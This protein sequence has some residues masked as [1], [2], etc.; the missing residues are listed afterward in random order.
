MAKKKSQKRAGSFL[1]YLHERYVGKDSRR[2]AEL[3][4][5]RAIAVVARQ[6]YTLRKA[7]GLT[8]RELAARVGTK[9]PVICR[10]EDDDYSGHSLSMLRRIA[11]ALGK[12]VEIRFVSKPGAKSA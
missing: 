2:Q 11:G 6:I 8:Q 3:E 9:D 1:E 7:A 10:L 12:R 5:A 4:E